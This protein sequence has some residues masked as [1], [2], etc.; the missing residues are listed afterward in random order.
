MEYIQGEAMH[1]G[2]GASESVLATNLAS[3]S[4]AY[5]LKGI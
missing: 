3:G 5:N 2:G 4:G 1:F